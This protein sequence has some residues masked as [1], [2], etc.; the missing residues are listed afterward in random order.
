MARRY[1][2]S[3]TRSKQIE[4]LLKADPPLSLRA[5]AKMTGTSHSQVQRVRDDLR[6]RPKLPQ[7]PLATTI[8][9][10][11]IPPPPSVDEQLGDLRD[12]IE[13]LIQHA[14]NCGRWISNLNAKLGGLDAKIEALRWQVE[15]APTTIEQALK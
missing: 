8:D 2:E 6:D 13:G 3:Y 14:V 7:V 4:E 1:G 15:G 5:I 11:W 9:E 10:P 12:E